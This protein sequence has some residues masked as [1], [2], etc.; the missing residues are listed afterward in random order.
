MTSPTAPAGPTGAPDPVT[1]D[2]VQRALAAEHAAVWSLQLV[3]AFVGQGV[4]P[5]VAEATTAHRARRDATEA[6]LRDRAT[7]PIAAEPA[8]TAPAPVTDEASAV[9]LLIA[10]E[11]DVAAAW[12]WVIEH[13]DDAGVR[14]MAVDAL[15]DAAVRATRWRRTAGSPQL[16]VP[17]PGAPQP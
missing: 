13:T 4:A 2:A 5:A 9:A 16:T 11:S 6:L 14:A 1:I 17:F 15:T 12:R 7:V 10:A 3:T 8:Y